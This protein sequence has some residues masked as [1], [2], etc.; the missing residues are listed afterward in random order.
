MLVAV[1]FTAVAN[2]GM[3]QEMARLRIELTDHPGGLRLVNPASAPITI[4][5]AIEVE[6][7]EERGWVPVETEF[8]AVARCDG[9]AAPEQVEVAAAATIEVV[10]WRG[11]SCSGQCNYVCRGNVYYGPGTFRFVVTTVPTGERLISPAFMLPRRP[12][13]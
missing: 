11:F 12:L 4:H 13:S 8:H 3:A 9:R 10:P 6:K 2:H 1:A 5:A 7:R